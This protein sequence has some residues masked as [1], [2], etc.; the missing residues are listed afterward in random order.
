MLTGN[1]SVLEHF[2]PETAAPYRSIEIDA[3]QI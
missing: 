2:G 3:V 1:A